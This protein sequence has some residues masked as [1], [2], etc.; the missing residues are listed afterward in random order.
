[1]GYSVKP[2]DF[3]VARMKEVFVSDLHR[4]VPALRKPRQER[5]KL[6]HEILVSQR[7]SLDEDD[8]LLDYLTLT[9]LIPRVEKVKQAIERIW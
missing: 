3:E 6:I 5:F 9:M 8:L 1:M 2:E 7:A 4:V